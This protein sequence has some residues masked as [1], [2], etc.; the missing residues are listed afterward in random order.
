MHGRLILYKRIASARDGE[1]L[2]DLQA[3]MIDRFG[4]LPEPTRV[5]FRATELKLRA[6]PLGVRKVDLGPRGGRVA[7]GP[8]PSVDPARVIQLIQKEPSRYRLEGGDRIRVTAD[9]P[10]AESR[11]RALSTLLDRLGAR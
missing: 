2:R 8:Q 10:D 3:E 5:L 9:L 4:L 7:F 1:Q 11:V 6:T